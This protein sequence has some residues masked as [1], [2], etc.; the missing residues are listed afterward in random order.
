MPL[1]K[2]DER[3]GFSRGSRDVVALLATCPERHPVTLPEE[4][5]GKILL[6]A[7]LGGT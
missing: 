4:D 1:H 2:S 7:A 3:S 6:V 5:F